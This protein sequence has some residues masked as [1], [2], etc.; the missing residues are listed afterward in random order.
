MSKR[1]KREAA[2]QREE[3]ERQIAELLDTDDSARIEAVRRYIES[4]WHS[5][6]GSA[7]ILVD[8]LTQFKEEPNHL[9]LAKYSPNKR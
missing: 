8:A 3:F 5:N 4:R 6:F 2:A 1:A 9:A 7:R